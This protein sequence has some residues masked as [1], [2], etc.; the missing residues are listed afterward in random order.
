MQ[1]A[2]L[3][4]LTLLIVIAPAGAVDTGK[5][6]VLGGLS[7]E[8]TAQ[9]GQ[10]YQGVI[11]L[12]NQGTKPAEVKVYQT[13]YTPLP[14]GCK[15]GEP[16]TS[17]RSNARWITVTPKQLVIP[18]GEEGEVYY[19]VSVPQGPELTG[20]YWSMVMVEPM[21]PISIQ[22]PKAEKE[23]VGVG[24]IS[25]ARYGIVMRTNVG[26]RARG[27]LR[28][29]GKQLLAAGNKRFL[30][31]DVENPGERVLRASIWAELYNAKGISLGRF[32]GARSHGMYPG[33]THRVRLDLTG[34][35][36]GKYKALLV[37]DCGGDEVFGAQYD[38]IIE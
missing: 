1:K 31:L 12:T 9:P 2:A 36:A 37:M 18:P 13:D 34:V 16:G 7:R 10:S 3:S 29:V 24:I 5:V 27:E 20:S 30:Q 32:G 19:M 11:L 6:G 26:A 21:R 14:G 8:N 15:Y 23:Q 28:I 22:Q 4:V 33:C 35:P 17:P 25:L 38:L